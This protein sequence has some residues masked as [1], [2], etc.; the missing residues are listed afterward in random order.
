MEPIIKN[1]PTKRW[2]L[3]QNIVGN[4]S[5]DDYLDF[6]EIYMELL[7]GKLSNFKSVR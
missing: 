2:V 5:R 6:Y 7:N 1:C 3:T 4:S